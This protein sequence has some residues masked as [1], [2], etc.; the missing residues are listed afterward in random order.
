MD[1]ESVTMTRLLGHQVNRRVAREER[2]AEG[3]PPKNVNQHRTGVV[4]RFTLRD[5]LKGI[6]EHLWTEEL[7]EQ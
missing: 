1:K 7:N 2:F 5:I 6:F 4:S 3:T